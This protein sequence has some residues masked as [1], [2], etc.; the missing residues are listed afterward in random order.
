MTSI[1][2]NMCINKLDD[3]V[4]KYNIKYHSTIK[5]QPVDAKSSTYTDFDKKNTKEGSKFKVGDNVRVSKYKNIIVKDY[6]TDQSKEVLVIK[7]VRNTLT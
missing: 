3:T 2:N 5:M 1:S 6:E 4:N 7:K